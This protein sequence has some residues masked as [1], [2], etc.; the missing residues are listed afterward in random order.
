MKPLLFIGSM[1]YLVVIPEYNLLAQSIKND[2]RKGN[3][4]FQEQKYEEARRVYQKTLEKPDVPTATR[5]NYGNALYKLDSASSA[6]NAYEQYAT[7]AEEPAS[8]AK[9]QY[10]IGNTFLKEQQF[11]K[12]VEHYKSA[13]R[14]NPNDEDARYNLQYALEKLKSQQNQD[15]N[16][17]NQDKNQQNQDKN[18]QNQDK[19]Q[20]SQDKNQQNQDKNQQNQDKNQQNQDK[21]QQNQDKNQQNQDKN[22]QNQDKNQQQNSGNEQ[23]KQGEKKKPEQ[24]K[25]GL[26]KEQA[27]QLLEALQREE[28]KVQEKVAKKKVSGKKV[29]VEKDW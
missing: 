17:Q 9:A 12:A 7:L 27:M 4:L 14:A 28:Q 10:N 16:Q 6:R 21:N 23:D 29:P 1:L 8:K 13:L 22:Q 3:T 11:E 25:T 15:K 2:V 18:Q 26:S 20:Q 19:N 24:G 5:Y